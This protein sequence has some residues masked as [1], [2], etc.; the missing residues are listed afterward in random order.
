MHMA[1]YEH[2]FLARQDISAQAV[3]TLTKEFSAI[4][5]EHGGKVVKTEY[6][7]LKTLA[8]KIKKSRKAHYTL[9]NIDADHSAIAEMERRMGLSTDVIRHMT[10]RVEEH[11]S[12]PSVQMRKSDR[13]ERPGRGGRGGARHDRGPRP[14]R[15]IQNEAPAAGDASAIDNS[16]EAV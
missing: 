11:E 10:I 1:L 6:W 12:E 4:I 2:V 8:Y 5:T 13:D 9:L 15:P 7:G 16:P 3:D 14:P